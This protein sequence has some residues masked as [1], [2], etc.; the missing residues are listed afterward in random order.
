[1]VDKSLK[2]T[3]FVWWLHVN[4]AYDYYATQL[5][6]QMEGFDTIY[7]NNRAYVSC[8]GYKI[9]VFEVRSKSIFLINDEE[10]KE[11]SSF[12]QK[13][14]DHEYCEMFN[15][16]TSEYKVTQYNIFLVHRYI[17]KVC[18]KIKYGFEKYTSLFDKNK[19]INTN[20]GFLKIGIHN[21][22]SVA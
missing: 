21:S 13:K 7:M 14:L 19:L 9:M 3:E 17:E 6:K 1:M 12:V 5:E 15:L 18:E 16:Y 8:L 2:K 20:L 11:K 4:S 22:F 10:N